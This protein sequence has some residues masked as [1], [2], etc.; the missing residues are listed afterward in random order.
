MN[1]QNVQFPEAEYR[2]FGQILIG[3][4][5]QLDDMLED[6]DVINIYNQIKSEAPQITMEELQTLVPQITAQIMAKLKKAPQE[7]QADKLAA[8]QSMRG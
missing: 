8:L 4:N 2:Q 3:G 5:P 1:P 7:G 6:Q